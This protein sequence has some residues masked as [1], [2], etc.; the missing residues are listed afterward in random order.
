MKQHF[1]KNIDYK[2]CPVINITKYLVSKFHVFPR[3]SDLKQNIKMYLLFVLCCQFSNFFFSKEKYSNFVTKSNLHKIKACVICILLC[4]IEQTTKKNFLP[5]ENLRYCEMSDIYQLFNL[6][7]ELHNAN[8]IQSEHQNCFHKCCCQLC[9]FDKF[10]I[11]FSFSLDYFVPFET[12][13]Y[14][15]VPLLIKKLKTKKIIL[16][17]ITEQI[18]YFEKTATFMK[19]HFNQPLIKKNPIICSGHY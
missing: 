10:L 11:I 12:R 3:K 2:G 19:M 8:V 18:K 16:M 14:C 7:N 13:C 1:K 6:T 5:V 17:L 4:I 9:Y 15:D